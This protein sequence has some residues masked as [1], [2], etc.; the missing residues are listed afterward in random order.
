M[1]CANLAAQGNVIWRLIPS[2]IKLLNL[3]ME[4]GGVGWG[5]VIPFGTCLG[6]SSYWVQDATS[7]SL[8]KPVLTI[9]V[10]R[11]QLCPGVAVQTCTG[12]YVADSRGRKKNSAS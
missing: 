6:V 4:V 8:K 2:S 3:E 10:E 7:A 11:A 9:Q 5:R 1:S 12:M